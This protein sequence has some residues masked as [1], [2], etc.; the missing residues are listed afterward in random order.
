MSNTC[1]IGNI[2]GVTTQIANAIPVLV[3]SAGQLGTVSSSK[4]FKNEIK[5]MD[6][7]QRIH[8]GAQAGDFPL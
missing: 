6:K 8:S 4:R 7:R 2:R 1:F 5:P 3:D